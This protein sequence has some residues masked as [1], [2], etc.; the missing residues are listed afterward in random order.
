MNVS[1][2][3][4]GNVPA[5]AGGQRLPFSPAI[6][7]GD[8]VFVSGQVGMNERGEIEPGGIEAQTRRTFNNLESVLALAGCSLKDVIKVTVWLDDTRDFWTFNKV[9]QEY[10][11]ENPPV[12]SCVRAQMMVDCKVEIEV[13]AYKPH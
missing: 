2:V 4:Y 12:R 3:I 11:P 5:G 8:F 10:F 13:T 1:K 6:R 9:Y 7:A